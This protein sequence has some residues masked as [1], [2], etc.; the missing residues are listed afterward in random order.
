MEKNFHD[1]FVEK[2]NENNRTKKHTQ[3]MSLSFIVNPK[4]E[5]CKNCS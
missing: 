4:I 3:G 5:G 1:K 2:L